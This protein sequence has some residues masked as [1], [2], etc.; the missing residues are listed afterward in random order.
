MSVLEQICADKLEHIKAR[1]AQ[2]PLSDLEAALKIVLP[3]RGFIKALKDKSPALIAE[4]KKASPSKGVIREN[5]NPVEI[6]QAY[7]S[8]GAACLSVLTDEPYFQGKDEY[9]LDVRRAV[10]LPIL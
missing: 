6:A 4:V 9:L 7:E 5:F 1:K 3:P 8:A 10:N 2:T